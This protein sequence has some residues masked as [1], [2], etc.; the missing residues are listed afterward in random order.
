[1]AMPQLLI[2][3]LYTWDLPMNDISCLG[4]IGD[5]ILMPRSNIQGK[6]LDIL[7]EFF[8]LNSSL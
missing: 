8:H 3:Y 6:N 5:W 4:R 7:D 2:F 1:M